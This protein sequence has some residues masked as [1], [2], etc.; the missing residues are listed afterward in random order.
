MTDMH[1]Y[2]GCMAARMC[3][4]VCAS[5]WVSYILRKSMQKAASHDKLY[6]THMATF[7]FITFLVYPSLSRLQFQGMGESGEPGQECHLRFSLGATPCLTRLPLL[8]QT[9]A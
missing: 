5:V 7:L 1:I 2:V 4:S 9:A 3:A 6:A 8:T